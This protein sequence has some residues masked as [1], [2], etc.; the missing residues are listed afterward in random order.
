M[1]ISSN[2]AKLYTAAFGSAKLPTIVGIGGWIGSWELW[3]QPLSILSESWRTISYD[4]RGSGASI[5]PI[6]TI[7]YDNL[8]SD[9][10][11][12]LDAYEVK[13]VYAGCR[14]SR[15]IDSSRRRTQRSTPNHAFGDRRWL[16][17]PHCGERR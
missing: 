7:T 14:V 8:V 1:F 12:V 6:Q 15:R 17:S 4:H 16:V 10:F 13:R 2:E 5:A 11:T 9:I 3:A